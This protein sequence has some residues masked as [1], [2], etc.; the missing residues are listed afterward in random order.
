MPLCAG[1]GQ[2]VHYQK[3]Q[4]G[5]YLTICLDQIQVLGD[6]S[7]FYS[8]P[9]FLQISLIYWPELIVIPGH[10]S[11]KFCGLVIYVVIVARLC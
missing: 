11:V 4:V 3:D 7:S 5:A 1:R 2:G 8:L 6:Y 9:A 10:L